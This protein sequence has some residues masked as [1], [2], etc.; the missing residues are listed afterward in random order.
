MHTSPENRI[1]LFTVSE[2]R[3]AKNILTNG[4][5][6]P[7]HFRLMDEVLTPEVM[8]RIDN[9]AGLLNDRDYIAYRLEYIAGQMP[10]SVLVSV[11]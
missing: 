10:F 1:D 4:N 3:K 9:E 2:V 5:G 6:A 8:R 11:T 7:A